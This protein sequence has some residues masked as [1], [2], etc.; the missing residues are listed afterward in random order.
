MPT[1]EIIGSEKGFSAD[2]TRQGKIDR[3]VTYRG[4]DQVLHVTAL[5]D[6]TFSLK[7]AEAAVYKAEAERRLATPHKFSTP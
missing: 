2:P 6:E 4:E 3:F 7:A 5:P 1:Y